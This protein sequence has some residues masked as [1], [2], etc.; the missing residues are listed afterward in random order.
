MPSSLTDDAATSILTVPFG[1]LPEDRLG[2]T[3]KGT[4]QIDIS[5]A[6]YGWFIAK[7][8]GRSAKDEVRLANPHSAIR[9]RLTC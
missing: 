2:L 6:G 9:I 4:I 5:A 1:T 7:Y 8:E 3:H